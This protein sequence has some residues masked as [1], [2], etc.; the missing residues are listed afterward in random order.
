MKSLSPMQRLLRLVALR[1]ISTQEV[2]AMPGSA[3]P[4]CDNMF[5]RA[6][7]IDARAAEYLA[8]NGMRV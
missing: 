2:A 5:S 7:G 1:G 6:A 3:S 8:L 4:P